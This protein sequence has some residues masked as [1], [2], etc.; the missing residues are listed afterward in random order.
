M[1]L[2]VIAGVGRRMFS[3]ALTYKFPCCNMKPAGSHSVGNVSS[4]ITI[5]LQVLFSS[6]SE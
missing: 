5:W 3:P 1:G 6:G 4:G 2:V